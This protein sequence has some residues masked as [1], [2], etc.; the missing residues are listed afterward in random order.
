MKVENANIYSMQQYGI[1]LSQLSQMFCF[2]NGSGSVYNGVMEDMPIGLGMPYVLIIFMLVVVYFTYRN[3]LNL[4]GIDMLEQQKMCAMLLLAILT[5]SYF[6]PW[7]MIQKIPVIGKWL[8]PYQF[9][10]RFIGM[11]TICG[12]LLFAYVAKDVGYLFE[13]NIRVVMWSL[14]SVIILIC[15]Q[16]I[17]DMKMGTSATIKATSGKAFDTVDVASNQEYLFEDTSVADLM[18]LNIVAEEKVLI[19]NWIRQNG[20][21]LVMCKNIS[22]E[23][24]KITLPLLN[25]KEFYAKDIKTGERL[26]IT[27]TQ[28]HIL[29]VVLP[30][31]YAGELEVYYREPIYWRLT[32]MLSALSLLG[33]LSLYWKKG[34]KKA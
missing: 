1:F 16:Y 13:K 2:A 27:N 21:I 11:V 19:D 5:S 17:M 28:E 22:D 6:F 18:N 3:R 12:L 20:K 32:E 9:A 25:Y 14:L 26:E 4:A 29:Q 8:T 30:K 34:Y 24:Q 31:E 33:C 10:S 23:E 7:N 15:G